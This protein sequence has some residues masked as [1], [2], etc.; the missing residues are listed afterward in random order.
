[1]S[2]SMPAP[3]AAPA[4]TATIIMASSGMVSTSL[5]AGTMTASRPAGQSHRV[6]HSHRGSGNGRVSVEGGRKGDYRSEP[7][8]RQDAYGREK[9]SSGRD[10]SL[11]M[12]MSVCV[13][14]PS[15]R[16]RI[17]CSPGAFQ[18]QIVF[19]L[20]QARALSASCCVDCTGQVLRK[21]LVLLNR[22]VRPCH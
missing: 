5:H 22:L 3:R 8:G 20:L 2:Q 7:I 12:Y 16:D 11:C 19:L 13:A 21:L 4:T 15:F 10:F 1:M 6:R 9:G 18:S 17:P 14:R